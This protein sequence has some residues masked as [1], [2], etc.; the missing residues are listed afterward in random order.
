MPECKKKTA[1]TLKFGTLNMNGRGSEDPT[2]SGGKWHRLNDMMRE[3]KLDVLAVNETHLDARSV[4]KL[5]DKFGKR[6]YLINSP[7]PENPGAK[8]GVTVILNRER[9][10]VHDVRHHVLIPGRAIIVSI[11]WH[12]KLTFTYLAVYA[13]NNRKEN[14][15]FWDRLYTIILS[16]NRIPL[17]D[18]MGGDL[19][20]VEDALDKLPMKRDHGGA[21]QALQRLVNALQLRDIW[22]EQNLGR[23][24]Y[25]CRQASTGSQSRIDRIY[26]SQ[27][28]AAVSQ[29]WDIDV[30]N[31][32]T[33]H[34]L[35]TA[36]ITNP[37]APYIGRGWPTWPKHLI[38][39]DRE[40]NEYIKSKGL[41]VQKT[42][43]ELEEGHRVRTEQLNAQILF[44]E[45]KDDIF[46][47]CRERA[48]IVVPRMQKAINQL[49]S[50]IEQ[51]ERNTDLAADEK[52]F[53]LAKLQESLENLEL[54]RYDNA[55]TSSKV[56]YRL[57]GET[58]SKYWS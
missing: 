2:A 36:E 50:R 51:M 40:L 47:K 19:N 6:L 53:S 52:I 56:R 21:V 39:G 54:R 15:E 18:A 38:N 10:N 13:P 46:A 1:S 27:D 24:T 44:K 3:K 31:F 12:A 28:V 55:K 26:A 23:T 41:T 17:P 4:D 33:D 43:Q 48:R 9:T 42:I 49:K 32:K 37:A 29:N 8:E 5:H 16:N 22:R 34:K 35:V 11:A 20:V 30:P 7:N 58:V 45:F 57:E 14:E 25:T